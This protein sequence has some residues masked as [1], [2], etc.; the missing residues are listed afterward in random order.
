MLFNEYRGR[1]AHVKK[2]AS[3]FAAHLGIGIAEDESDGS[4]EITL[5]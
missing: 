2:G 3:L 4:E 1:V 5:S